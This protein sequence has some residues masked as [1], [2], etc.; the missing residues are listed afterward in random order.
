MKHVQKGF[1]LIELMI[2]VAIIG[3]LAAVAIPAYQ[4]Y[5]VKTKLSR[6][7]TTI[8]SVRTALAVYYN[9][10]GGFPADNPPVVSVPGGVPLGAMPA[11]GPNNVWLSLNFSK[12]PILPAEVASLLYTSPAPVLP[13]PNATT[14]SLQLTLTKIRATADATNIDGTNLTITPSPASIG[15]SAL[16][17]DYTCISQNILVKNY[18]K[19]ASGAP[20]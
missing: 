2:V 5:I 8:D 13:S 18:F 16:T 10:Q 19:K 14:F 7:Q 20:C 15:A 1:T 3:I 6:V 9:E 4:D 17:W 12:T 11:A